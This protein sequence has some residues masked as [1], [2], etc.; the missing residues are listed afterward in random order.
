L[1]A[2]HWDDFPIKLH[3]TGLDYCDDQRDW[4]YYYYIYPTMR[5]LHLDSAVTTPLQ[6]FLFEKIERCGLSNDYGG[7]V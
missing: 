7:L 4:W 5:R 2:E 3:V 6:N 1:R